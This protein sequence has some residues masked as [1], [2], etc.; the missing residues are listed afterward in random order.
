[1]GRWLIKIALLSISFAFILLSTL[2]SSGLS[3][4]DSRLSVEIVAGGFLKPRGV[5]ID[6]SGL[7]YVTDHKAGT[8]TRIA[9]DQSKTI[10]AESLERPVGLTFD[11]NGRLLIAEERSGRVVRLEED[12]SLSA[13]VEGIKKPRWLTMS[14][15]GTL[16]ISARGL[17]RHINPEPNNKSLKK[18]EVI[19]ALSSAGQLSVF[20][21]GFEKLQGV[22][23]SDGTLYAAAKGLKGKGKKGRKGKD[24]SDGVIFQIPILA[25]GTAGALGQL[26]P[27]DS[28]KKP[29][30]LARDRLGAFFV[31]AKEL[32]LL[33]DKSKRVIT[34]VSPDGSLSLVASGLKD[35]QGVGFDPDGNLVLADGKSGRVLRFLAPPP[36]PSLG[37][38]NGFVINGIAQGGESPL[39][40]SSAGDINGDGIDDLIIGAPSADDNAGQSYVV[41]GTRQGFPDVLELSAL[42]GTNGFVINGIARFDFAGISV[43]AA[44]DVNRDGI[45]DVIIGANGVDLGGLFNVGQSYV[46]FGTDQGFPAALE[47]SA[48]DGSN[49]FAL[50]GVGLNIFENTGLSVSAAGDVNRDGIDDVII[51]A[52]S[53]PIANLSTAGE[54]FVVFGTDQG[55]PALLE[56]SALDGANGFALNG[57]TDG[58]SSGISVSSAGDVN[59]D[60][61]DD[62][63]IGANGA[64]PNGIPR[65]GQSYVVFGTKHGFLPALELS[66]LD[67]A[68]GFALNGIAE[69][70]SSGISVSSAGDFNGDRIDDLIIGAPFAS[71]DSE[72]LL[73]G[74]SYVVLGTDQGFPA[75]LELSA[76]N[77]YNGF[78]LN[79]IAERN[80]SGWSVS[81]A[82][83]VNGDGA[84]DVIIGSNFSDPIDPDQPSQGQSYVVFGRHTGGGPTILVRYVNTS[85]SGTAGGVSFRDEDIVA[86]DLSTGT[87]SMH[88][89]GSDVGLGGT[90]QDLNAFHIDADGSILLSMKVATTLPDVGPVEPT[91]IVRFVPTSTG[92]NTAGTF[93]MVLDGSDVELEDTQREPID[94]IGIL[95]DGRF[96]ISTRGNPSAS[97]LSGAKD[98]DLIA[99]NATQLGP[100]TIGTWEL[101]FD[102][103]DVGLGASSADDVNGIW[104]DDTNGDIYF[105]TRGEPFDIFVCTPDSVG[106][107]TRCTYRFFWDPQANGLTA[108]GQ[109]DGISLSR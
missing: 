5:V 11:L 63:I 51:G 83:D 74:Q 62:F 78:V 43:S 65:A 33:G 3:D 88:F 84:D 103:S 80:R 36:P 67:G 7:I 14:E 70:D 105:T 97:G 21:D 85:I 47:L 17:T 92:D 79:G 52:P 91:D 96:V 56:L 108:A 89:D 58:D 107:D 71:P 4:I 53:T 101:Y 75:V 82:G 32:T 26:G 20:A 72:K 76:L 44:G 69:G 9:A 42:D 54:S 16:F 39:N 81:S 12:G 22:V 100:D 46:V 6:P 24:K 60:G 40:V 49:G 48:L 99:F 13:L 102:G 106:A 66:A 35:P 86:Y 87:W 8:V 45:N 50:N 59:G 104:V 109:L 18:R 64:S 68:N 10:V 57:V 38:S 2:H 30:G 41:F 29:I 27:S 95:P 77:G 37:G 23:A 61:I 98:E 1:M 15:T 93:A 31:T 94:A 19:L 25:D 55:F 34:K 90:G 28:F 73:A